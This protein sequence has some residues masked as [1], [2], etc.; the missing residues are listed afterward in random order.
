MSSFRP[1]V[2]ETPS[3]APASSCRTCTKTETPGVVGTALVVVATAG[4]GVAVFLKDAKRLESA[5]AALKKG[6]SQLENQ[7][8]STSSSR[9][10]G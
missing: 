4:G 6:Q 1:W 9:L 5:Q 7:V 8:S 3:G 10:S 2:K